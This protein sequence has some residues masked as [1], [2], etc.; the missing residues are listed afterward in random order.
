MKYCCYSH[1]VLLL[2]IAHSASLFLTFYISIFYIKISFILVSI[3]VYIYLYFKDIF[4]LD[5]STMFPFFLYTTLLL[6]SLF[7]FSYLICICVVNVCIFHQYMCFFFLILLHFK[8]N[9]L[10]VF[11]YLQFLI[12][13]HIS[14]YIAI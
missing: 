3:F 5:R 13:V 4:Y 12:L 1:Y 6:S 10:I 11:G 9:I 2:F 14:M 7:L 8:Y